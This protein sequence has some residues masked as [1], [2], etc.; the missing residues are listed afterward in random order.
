[1]AKKLPTATAKC[2]FSS[3][4]PSCPE[5]AISP[6]ASVS[7]SKVRTCARDTPKRRAI[8]EIETGTGRLGGTVSSGLPASRMLNSTISPALRSTN[9]G[10]SAAWIGRNPPTN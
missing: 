5:R 6:C 4:E 1:L 10:I 9:S 3:T 8:H 7:R 2:G